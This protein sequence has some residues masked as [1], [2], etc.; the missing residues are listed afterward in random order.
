MVGD[1]EH[2]P[3]KRPLPMQSPHV[4]KEEQEAA[5]AVATRPAAR[6]SLRVMG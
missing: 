3:Q 2:Q 6:R 5:A 4:L 1:G